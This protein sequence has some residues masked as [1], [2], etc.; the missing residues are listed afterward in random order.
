VPPDSS[1]LAAALPPV[2]TAGA[3][4]PFYRARM[5]ARGQRLPPCSVVRR[6]QREDKHIKLHSRLAAAGMPHAL[7][8][9]A[10]S[11][12]AG[13]GAMGSMQAVRVS[14]ARCAVGRQ[15]ACKN[16]GRSKLPLQPGEKWG[17]GQ[18]RQGFDS[19]QARSEVD[20]RV[21]ASCRSQREAGSVVAN[22]RRGGP[23][24]AR[25]E[26]RLPLRCG[27]PR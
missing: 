4:P 5:R 1:E 10:G 23:W 20:G 26:C 17:G 8:G 6:V 15:T 2:P 7:G 3:T 22:K 19:R 9:R 21:S 25:G 13:A 18:S 24:V 11:S 12:A 27:R 16:D 14:R